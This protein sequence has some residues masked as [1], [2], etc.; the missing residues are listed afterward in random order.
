[1]DE[2]TAAARTPQDDRLGPKSYRGFFLWLAGYCAVCLAAGLMPLPPDSMIRLLLQLTAW[3]LVLLA[4]I[5]R[6]TGRIYWYNGVS[7]AQAAEAGAR[8]RWDYAQKHLRRF[9][10]F[11]GGFLLFTGVTVCW[12]APVWVDLTVFTC[13]LTAAAVS[14]MNFRL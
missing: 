7:Y 5:I 14:T 11:A 6:R 8:A 4:W 3:D 1:M 10:Q 12:R 9:V 2:R 13:G